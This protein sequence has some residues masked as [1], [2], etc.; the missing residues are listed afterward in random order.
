[1]DLG[2]DDLDLGCCWQLL[3]SLLNVLVSSFCLYLN[4][5][6]NTLLVL[7][8][9]GI[10]RDSTENLTPFLFSNDLGYTQTLMNLGR[11]LT[12]VFVI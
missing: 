5:H 3:F 11:T 1:M 12:K 4:L 9:L 2:T 6:K 7:V 8:I 10:N